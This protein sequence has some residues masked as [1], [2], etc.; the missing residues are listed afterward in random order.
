MD[1]VEGGDTFSV[2]AITPKGNN[3]ALVSPESTTARQTAL[4]EVYML[5]RGMRDEAREATSFGG[6]CAL[7]RALDE[8]ADLVQGA[9][10]EPD[11]VHDWTEA[12]DCP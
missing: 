2:M 7:A 1:K 5:L 10:L 6:S 11:P 9:S 3:P 8:A 12:K 4:W